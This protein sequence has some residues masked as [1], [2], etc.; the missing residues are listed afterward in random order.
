MRSHVFTLGESFKRQAAALLCG[1]AIAVSTPVAAGPELGVYR[2]DVPNGPAN[3]DAFSQWLGKPVELAEAF[4]AADSWDN[5]DGAGWQLGPWSQWVRAQ[6][7]RNL[8]LAVP[9][10]PGISGV[11]LAQC[12]A[13]QYD[14]RWTNLA[15]ELAYYGLHWAYLRLGWEPDGGWYAW[16]APQGQ[17]NEANYAGCF[18]RIVQVMRNAQPAS[19]WKFVWNPTTAWWD[20]S[21]L[22]AIW[23]GN[24]YVDVVGID[25]YD[26]SWAS[27]TYPYPST[28]DAS[29]RLARQQTAWS[30]HLW[31]LSTIRNF[32]VGH[33]KPMAI[34]EWGAAL[35]PD[36]HG[37]GD[38]AYFVQKMYEFIHDPANYV[39]F[40]SYFNV[41]A[42]D[43]DARLTDSVTGDAPSGASRFPESAQRFRQLFGAATPQPEPTPAPTP[44]PGSADTTPPTVSIA[45]PADGSVLYR[46]TSVTL[47]AGASD[48]VGVVSVDFSV[49]GRH[50]CRVEAP[51]W[52]CSWRTFNGM[53]RSYDVRA[54][55]TD[56]SG[57]TASASQSY[58]GR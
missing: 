18:R 10:L 52:R 13:G 53:T 39:A 47:E 37:G 29:C 11:S 56:L 36:G 5:I 51:P 17:G 38:N 43:I 23:P 49:N 33:G 45:S 32:A 14:A 19:Q 31:Y 40:H 20:K 58:P 46:R 54:T 25:L 28:C 7:G 50:V 22:D 26:Q 48:N 44:E 15:N 8:I 12:A 9:M 30:N 6:L 16:A 34:P 57:N 21:Y 2:W 35:R 3:V 4:E 1:A 41:S 27:G 24:E 55:A 42:S